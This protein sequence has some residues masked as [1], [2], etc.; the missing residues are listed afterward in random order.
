MATNNL[1]PVKYLDLLIVFIQKNEKK[2]AEG[3]LNQHP[4]IANEKCLDGLEPIFYCIRNKA[5]K[6]FELLLKKM[7]LNEELFKKIY[8]SI[9]EEGTPKMLKI[10]LDNFKIRY[11]DPCLNEKDKE[12]LEELERNNQ[13]KNNDEDIEIEMK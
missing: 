10:F 12:M 13:P 3:L 2:N 6:I 11:D 5:C 9:K 4:L 8:L 7:D 1:K